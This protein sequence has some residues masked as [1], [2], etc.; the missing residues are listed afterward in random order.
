M[1]SN[2]ATAPARIVAPS[3]DQEHLPTLVTRLGDDVMQLV[4]SKLRLLKVE[5][6]EEANTFLHGGILIAVGGVIATVGFALVNVAVA[7]GVATLFANM[8]LSPA[9]QYALGFI[10]TGAVYLLIGGI[11]VKVVQ[12]RLAR[13]ELVPPKT[14]EEIRKDAQWLKKEL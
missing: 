11:T 3:N 6:K 13:Q 4:D 8:N 12:S 9:A 5:I 1:A 14:V 7:L 2:L 10:I